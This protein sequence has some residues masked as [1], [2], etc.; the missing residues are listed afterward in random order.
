M[1]KSSIVK[2]QTK[3]DNI[4]RME[5]SKYSVGVDQL[6]DH[7]ELYTGVHIFFIEIQEEQIDTITSIMTQLSIKSGS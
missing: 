3:Q 6:E 5:G 1:C 7:R 4:P 2:F